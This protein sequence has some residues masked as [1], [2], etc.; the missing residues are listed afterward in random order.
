MKKPPPPSPPPTHIPSSDERSR[1]SVI[2]RILNEAQHSQGVHARRAKEL[3]LYR[4]KHRD[5][6]LADLWKCLLPIFCILRREP[7]VERVVRFVIYFATLR[8][9]IHGA[10][11]DSFLEEF[12]G[13]LLFS[14]DASNKAVR[15]RSCQILSEVGLNSL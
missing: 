10:D 5:V 8:D 3:L 6:F 7:S 2:A 15:L 9:Q 4:S 13:L 1:E 12:F 14:T 11:C